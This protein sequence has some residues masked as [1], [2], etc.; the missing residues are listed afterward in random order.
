M[1][2]NTGCAGG[3]QDQL[4][5]SKQHELKN[6]RFLQSFS[7]EKQMVIYIATTVV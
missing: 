4:I 2:E 3:I 7:I 6:D 1:S 5:S